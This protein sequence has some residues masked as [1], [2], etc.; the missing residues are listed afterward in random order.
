[1]NTITEIKSGVK[2]NVKNRLYKILCKNE[3]KENWEKDLDK[4]MIELI[5]YGERNQTINY[6]TLMTKL[7]TLKYLRFEYFR[8]T[9]FDCMSLV[10]DLEI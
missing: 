6:Y 1:M 5:G 4:L 8:S 3:E 2:N 7:S 9:I 10:G